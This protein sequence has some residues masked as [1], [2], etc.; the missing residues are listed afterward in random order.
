M[1]LMPQKAITKIDFCHLERWV[2]KPLECDVFGLNVI[3]YVLIRMKAKNQPHAFTECFFNGNRSYEKHMNPED[4]LLCRNDYVILSLKGALWWLT[5][6]IGSS[7]SILKALSVSCKYVIRSKH[8]ILMR[9][10]G[11]CSFL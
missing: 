5:H 9:L 7:M 1:L 10:K 3:V 11:L 6:S 4:D 8:K 2:W